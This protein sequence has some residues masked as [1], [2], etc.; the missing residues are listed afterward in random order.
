MLWRNDYGTDR[1]DYGRAL[2]VDTSGNSFLG[3]Q[4]YGDYG[5]PHQGGYDAFVTKIDSDGN[6]VWVAQYGSD[7][8]DRINGVAIGPTGDIYAVGQTYGVIEPGASAGASFVTKIG[9]DGTYQ[10]T[11]QFGGD[12]GAVAEA[13]TVDRTGAV[14]ITGKANVPGTT[15]LSDVFIRRF[16]DDG[17]EIWADYLF[18]DARDIGYGIAVDDDLTC[19]IA[20]WTDG[21]LVGP[22]HGGTDG[23]VV[24]YTPEPG[25]LALLGL[26]GVALLRRR[27]R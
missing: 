13:V 23:F 18:S 22:S 14:W 7:A 3:G 21:S 19:Y 8:T 24:A 16:T 17:Q 12:E 1:Q 26:G 20:G 5:A 2:A 25:T 11:R 6:E 27:S 15:F 10:W 4:T 9:A